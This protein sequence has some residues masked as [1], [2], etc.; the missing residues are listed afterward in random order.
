MS[1]RQ[2][3]QS[4]FGLDQGCNSPRST[5]PLLPSTYEHIELNQYRRPYSMKANQLTV[6]FIHYLNEKRRTSTPTNVYPRKG[7]RNKKDETIHP[8]RTRWSHKPPTISAKT[9]TKKSD[10]KSTISTGLR[11]MRVFIWRS[12][13]QEMTWRRA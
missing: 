3:R 8:T 6:I 4:S 1:F 5:Y 7:K 13:D 11:W 2:S 12:R 9:W 10:K